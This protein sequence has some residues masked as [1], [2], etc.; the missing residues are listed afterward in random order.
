MHRIDDP[1]A[2]A[3]LPT[4]KQPGSPGFFTSGSPT[5][6]QEATIVTDDWANSVQ[7]EIAYIIEQSG[8]TLSKTD[9]TQL[10]QALGRLT[11]RRLSAP[12]TFYVSTTGSDANDGLTQ[13][14]AFASPQHAYEFIRDHID[15]N[16]FQ[17]TIQMADGTYSAM[18]LNF[19][20]VGPAPIV[21][22]NVSDPSK[23]IINNA[24]GAA[25][26]CGLGAYIGVDSFTVQ[27]GGGQVGDYGA[28]GAGLSVSNGG[29]IFQ[30]NMHFGP[31]GFAHMASFFSG[32]ISMGSVGKNYTIAGPAQIHMYGGGGYIATADA[33]IT[34]VG[35]PAFAIA[36]AFAGGGASQMDAWGCTFSGAATGMRYNVT[37]N[38]C[39]NV[40]GAGANYFPGSTAGVVATGGIYA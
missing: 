2:V 21:R 12:T 29:I 22:G 18:A 35:T 23:V 31:C 10:F 14:T 40:K 15:T 6:G 38:A 24:N 11:R 25:V 16:G 5:T 39:V 34:I 37:N 7:E 3:A 30:S 26:G 8:L 36:F 19:P 1:S 32:V 28:I 27:G 9:R 20:V 33:A 4:P 13:A 17:T